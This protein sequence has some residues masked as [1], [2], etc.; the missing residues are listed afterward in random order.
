MK[1]FKIDETGDFVI[2]P[3]TH[4]FAMVDGADEV[5][6]RIKATL[7]I[8]YGEMVNIAPAIGSDYSSFFGKKINV[9]N[10]ISDMQAAITSQVPEVESIKD[11]K[12]EKLPERKLSVTFTAFIKISDNTE[13]REIG[14]VFN[15]E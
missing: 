15:I 8:R 3:D 9:N 5:A 7:S 11:F 14:E 12:F 1:D 13:E 6:Q 10:A 4:Q 2:D